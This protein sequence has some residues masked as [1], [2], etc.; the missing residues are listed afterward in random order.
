MRRVEE[1]RA[2]VIKHVSPTRSRR[3]HSEPEET[4]RGFG[5]HDS[6]HA[7]G[8]CTM[9]GC[10]ILGRMWRVKMRRSEAPMPLAASINSFSLT[11]ST[12]LAQGAHSRP[13]RRSR[14]PE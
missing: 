14:V 2:R 7:D 4:E 9:S 13:I 11:A 1:M 5:K 12:S 3:R 6:R 8:R 10:R